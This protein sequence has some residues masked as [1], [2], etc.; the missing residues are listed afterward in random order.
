MIEDLDDRINGSK[1][2]GIDVTGYISKIKEMMERLEHIK[3][4]DIE[5]IQELYV[6]VKDQ[7][8]KIRD[9]FEQKL[10]EFETGKKMQKAEEV[11]SRMQKAPSKFQSAQP[12][13]ALL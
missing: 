13:P 11:M 6:T 2:I 9:E 12:R 1:A 3:P 5:G 7:T 4:N 10:T 8:L